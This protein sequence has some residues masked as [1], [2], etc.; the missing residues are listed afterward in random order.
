MIA[1]PL[2]LG[3]SPDGFAYVFFGLPA[4]GA[5]RGADPCLHAACGMLLGHSRYACGN[6]MVCG[7]VGSLACEDGISIVAGTG[8]IG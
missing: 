2:Y 5:D 3:I 6:D 4:Y 1:A 7:W 8:S